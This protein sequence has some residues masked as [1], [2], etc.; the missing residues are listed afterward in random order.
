MFRKECE[1]KS[2]ESIFSYSIKKDNK[3]FIYWHDKLVKIISGENAQVF[4]YK[5][6]DTD[7]MEAQR[8]MAKVTGNIKR[9]RD[10]NTDTIVI[11]G[12]HHTRSKNL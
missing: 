5:I 6:Q 10:E 9:K 11:R 3:I 8:I 1:S 12:A 7:D 4:L 2:V